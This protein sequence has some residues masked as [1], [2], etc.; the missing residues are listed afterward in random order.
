[1]TKE[2]LKKRLKQYALSVARLVL[3]L[4]YNTVNK[5]YSDQCNRAASSAAANYRAACRAK[6][7]ADFINKLKIVEEELD[8]SLFFEEMIEYINSTFSEEIQTIYKEGNELLSI[9]VA[10][11]NTLRRNYK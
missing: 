8:E 10:S 1:M 9:I 4:P 3:K 2:E 7:N 6:S 5:N 11:L